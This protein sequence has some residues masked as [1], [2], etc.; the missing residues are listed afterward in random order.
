MSERKISVTYLNKTIEVTKDSTCFDVFSYLGLIKDNT[1][2]SYSENPIVGA[3]VNGE[4][5]SLFFSLPSSSLIVPIRVFDSLGRRIYRHTLSFLLSFAAR[6]VIEKKTLVIG[7]SL[8]DGFYFYFSD[9]SEITISEVQELEREMNRIVRGK[10]RIYYSLMRGKEAQEYFKKEGK[11]ETELLLASRND[12]FVPLY[13]C[14]DYLQV[15]YEPLAP[16]TSLLTEWELR[17]Y[18]K[19]VLLRYPVSENVYSVAQ[20]FHDNP[21]LFSVFEE[22]REWGNLLSVRSVGEMNELFKEGK[23]R[24]YIRLSE[25]LQR[26]KIASIADNIKERDAHFVFIAGPSSS[27]KTTFALRLSEELRLLGYKTIKVSLD[28]Y[29]NPPSLAPVDENGKPDLEDITAL[30]L[31]LLEEQLA[32]LYKGEKVHLPQYDFTTHITTFNEEECFVDEKTV[33]VLEG[34]HA[35]NPR[36]SGKKEG[37]KSYK[38]YISAL[39]QLNLDDSNRV[40]TTDNRLLRRL[41]R[42]YR[43]R[44]MSAIRTLSMW[45]SVTRGEKKHIFP[46][47][48]N[49]DTMFNSALDYEEGVLSTYVVPLLRGVKEEDGECYTLSRRLL[50]FLDNIYPIEP[51]LVPSDSLLREFIGGSDYKA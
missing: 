3:L 10:E 14:E 16:N 26:R 22:Y 9:G 47:Q 44:G 50:S 1:L 38:I 21:L 34:I 33:L 35:L 18:Q 45:S 15:S 23:T 24:E 7:H 48:N 28:D 17:K 51:S 40:S 20:D 13:K 25:D 29:Y 36:I 11:K 41:V 37:D 30:N 39:T 2:F 27:G 31:D 42:D 6:R 4:V 8:G 43:T 5:R 32:L 46:Y 12:S 49:A 19:G